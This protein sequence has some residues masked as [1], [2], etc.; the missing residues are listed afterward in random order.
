MMTP[1]NKTNLSGQEVEA[2]KIARK[3]LP[4]V[5][6]NLVLL[7]H[8][9]SESQRRQAMEL[10]LKYTMADRNL[11]L[12]ADG[13]IGPAGGNVGGDL[14]ITINKVDARLLEVMEDLPPRLMVKW[15]EV[16]QEIEEYAVSNEIEIFEGEV[17]EEIGADKVCA[18]GCGTPIQK[19]ST[20]AKG[21][22]FKAHVSSDKVK[23][24]REGN[25]LKKH[26]E[27]KQLEQMMGK[28]PQ[29]E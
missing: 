25:P 18:C 24:N 10:L 19:T 3:A 9:P 1:D 13:T 2:L 6:R 5:M 14:N 29:G 4:A 11:Q 8:S 17:V 15:A 7:C 22:H 12:M 26:I 16:M 23:Q 21:H 27:R 28:V 20:W